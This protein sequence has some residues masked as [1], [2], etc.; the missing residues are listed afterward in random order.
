MI[1]LQILKI[2][3]SNQ[4]KVVEKLILTFKLSNKHEYRNFQ[5]Q[6]LRARASYS[7]LLAMNNSLLINPELIQSVTEEEGDDEDA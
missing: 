2:L 5:M 4:T 6:A 3:H 7:L 1:I